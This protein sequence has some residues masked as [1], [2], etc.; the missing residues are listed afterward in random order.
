V[1][2]AYAGVARLTQAG[3]P[4]TSFCPIG[5]GCALGKPGLHSFGVNQLGI[6]ELTL[7]ELGGLSVAADRIYFTLQNNNS[8]SSTHIVALRSDGT[9]VREFGNNGV[10]QRPTASPVPR[11]TSFPVI[12]ASA[13]RTLL[14]AGE[15]KVGWPTPA[16]AAYTRLGRSGECA[17]EFAQPCP[18]ALAAGTPP[19]Q[20]MIVDDY[21]RPLLLTRATSAGTVTLIRLQQ[22]REL[23]SDGYE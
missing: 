12:L 18:R 19:I 1:A 15:E 3:L 4:D 2:P 9:I 5:G 23:L 11:F 6:P 17:A 22:Q 20:Q 7:P 21:D 10:A 13:R 8:T 16:T 14:I